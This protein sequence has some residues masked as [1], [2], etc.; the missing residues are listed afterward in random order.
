MVSVECHEIGQNL[1]T[2]SLELDLKYMYN[3]FFFYPQCFFFFFVSGLIFCL[4]LFLIDFSIFN[5]VLG[6]RHNWAEG[7]EG[8]HMHP[9]PHSIRVP[10]WAAHL[11]Q[12][13]DPKCTVYL[14]WASLLVLHT[15]W[16]WWWFSLVII[17]VW[18]FAIPWTVAHQAPLS[19]GIN[20]QWHIATIKE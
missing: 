7:T 19:I 14:H 16:V 5:P 3:C 12:L 2:C 1:W 6:S 17:R 8:S 15:L 13:M 18:L 20:L 10:H 9:S 4:S 11:V